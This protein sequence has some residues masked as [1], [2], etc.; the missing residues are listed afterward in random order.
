MALTL[1]EHRLR[2]GVVELLD[3]ADEAGVPV[4][5][6]SNAHSGRSHRRLL[7]ELGIEQRFAVQI[8]SDEAGIRK[9]H[10]D[11]LH[12]A[13][14]ALGISVGRSWYVGDTLDRDLVAGRRAGAGAV[15]LIRS[16][17]TDEPPFPVREVPDAVLDTP[18]G[19]IDLMRRALADEA[20][21]GGAAHDGGPAADVLRS[22]A[23]AVRPDRATPVRVLLLDHG[24]VV[25]ATVPADRPLAGVAE[26][27]LRTLGRAGV[28][29]TVD[30]ALHLVRTAHGRY[31]AH[32]GARA[33]G[34][35]LDEVTPR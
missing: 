27:V 1:T 14:R 6:V 13:A 32:K 18:R 4:G 21:D 10:P 15:V 5:I 7:A 22:R 20:H 12:R 17:H 26:A 11:M 9:P 23:G 35:T 34:R 29:I 31:K 16:Q 28:E 3:L 30:E 33:A 2:D 24:G 8:Y 19:L 25:S